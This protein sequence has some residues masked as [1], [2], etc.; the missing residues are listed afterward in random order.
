MFRTV[1]ALTVALFSFSTPAV[2]SPW[3]QPVIV[4][5]T[6]APP[7]PGYV[8]AAPCPHPSAVWNPGRWAWTGWAWSWQAGYWTVP[9]P[10]PPRRY[11]TPMRPIPYGVPYGAPYG[12]PSQGHPG[13]GH[14]YGHGHGPGPGYGPGHGYAHSGPSPVPSRPVSYP[15][16]SRR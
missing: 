8:Q 3:P 15:G 13:N 12:Q 2:A 1:A 14:A 6:P 4:V 11:V 5:S 7:H 16:P 10:P 9:A